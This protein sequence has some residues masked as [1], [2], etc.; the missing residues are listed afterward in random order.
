VTLH[1]LKL[2]L[3]ISGLHVTMHCGTLLLLQAAIQLL[4]S[5]AY[6]APKQLSSCLPTIVPR[7]TGNT[8]LPHCNGSSTEQD[9][10]LF[11]QLIY[12][13]CSTGSALCARATYRIVHK[14]CVCSRCITCCQT[15]LHSVTHK[16]Y[17]Y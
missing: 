7:L 1:T 12:I 15:L 9:C 2:S 8:S 11:M 3:Y 13:N 5:M 4:G 14:L 6:C 17:E 16:H 10:A